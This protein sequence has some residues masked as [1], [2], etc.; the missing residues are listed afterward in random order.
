MARIYH[1]VTSNEYKH[2]QITKQTKSP[3]RLKFKKNYTFT[4]TLSSKLYFVLFEDIVLISEWS[5]VLY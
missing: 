1:T 4:V 3:I 5:Q 2:M